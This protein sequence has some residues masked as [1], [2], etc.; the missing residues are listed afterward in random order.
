MAGE[1]V[2]YKQFSAKSGRSNNQYVIPSMNLKLWGPW[3]NTF[4][5]DIL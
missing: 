3:F 2:C 4:G 5:N 1:K